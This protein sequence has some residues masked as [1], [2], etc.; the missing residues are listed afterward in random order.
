MPIDLN[1]F[2][3]KDF[4]HFRSLSGLRTRSCSPRAKP[5]KCTKHNAIQK[6][7]VQCTVGAVGTSFFWFVPISVVEI[8]M[9]YSKSNPL[10]LVVIREV[11]ISFVYFNSTL[12]PSLY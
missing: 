11:A 10:H 6:G 2:V 3:H 9:A 5:T 8:I 4:P 1:H 12:N 7:C